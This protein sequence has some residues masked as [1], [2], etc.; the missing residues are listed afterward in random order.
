MD[1]FGPHLEATLPRAGAKQAIGV[2]EQIL[3]RKKPTKTKQTIKLIYGLEDLVVI[4]C[5]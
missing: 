1:C 2:L 5:R 3:G 4:I